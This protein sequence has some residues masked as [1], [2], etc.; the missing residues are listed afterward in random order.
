[1][2][3]QQTLKQTTVYRCFS[4]AAEIWQKLLGGTCLL[5]FILLLIVEKLEIILNKHK[6]GI[7]FCAVYFCLTLLIKMCFLISIFCVLL[8]YRNW[9][10]EPWIFTG[11]GTEYWNFGTVTTLMGTFRR[12]SFILYKLYFLSPYP[13]LSPI[14]LTKSFL[15]F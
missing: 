5:F 12:K 3:H 9:Y 7:G 14:P 2:K 8:W 6:N 15:H 10:R 4:A 13:N 11:I 1:M